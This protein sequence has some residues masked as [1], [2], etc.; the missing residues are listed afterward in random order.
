MEKPLVIEDMENGQIPT[1]LKTLQNSCRDDSI[2]LTT[3][4]E[5]VLILH[6][7]MLEMSFVPIDNQGEIRGH[8]FNY[9]RVI[10]LSE[11]MP[12][13]WKQRTDQYKLMYVLKTALDYPCTLVMTRSSEDL[14]VNLHARNI[15]NVNFSVVLDSNAYIVSSS[16]CNIRYQY[17]KM[18]SFRFKSCIAYPAKAN[19][20]S[21]C[22]IKY[23]SFKN[24]PLELMIHFVRNYLDEDSILNLERTCRT[25]WGPRNV[26]QF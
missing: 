6:V 24:L 8:E 26:A 11:R 2:T 17:M 25:F 14:L 18:L 5:L 3:F 12:D 13:G 9:K 1:S 20:L 7:L 10:K 19:I 21:H 16:K 4:D 23:P 15:D 22:G